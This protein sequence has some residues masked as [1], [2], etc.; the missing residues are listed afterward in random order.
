ME[1]ISIDE[2]TPNNYEAVLVYFDNGK[3]PGIDIFTWNDKW[4]KPNSITHWMPL[5]EPPK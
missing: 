2:R 4:Y 5:P 1:W 3:N